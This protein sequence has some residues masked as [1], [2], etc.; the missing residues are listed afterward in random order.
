MLGKNERG[1]DSWTKEGRLEKSGSGVQKNSK[2]NK[3]VVESF[4]GQCER[5]GEGVTARNNIRACAK[6]ELACLI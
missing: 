5:D 3:T 4:K 2:L 1:Q 6:F